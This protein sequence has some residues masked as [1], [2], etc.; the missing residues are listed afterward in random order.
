[1][2]RALPVLVWKIG[3]KRGGNGD[4]RGIEDIARRLGFEL[5][6]TP[7][8]NTRIKQR[9]RDDKGPLALVRDLRNRLAHGELSFAECGDGVTV[10]DLRDLK[11]RTAL[12]L[13]EVVVSFN[14]Y[15]DGHQFLLPASRP[16]AGAT[17]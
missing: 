6:I 2:I 16:S 4:D 15:I 3:D 11:D 7:A 14:A 12:Y 17:L 1:L 5:Q 10:T 13:R 9:V 8:V